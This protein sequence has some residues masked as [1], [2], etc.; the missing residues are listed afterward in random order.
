V[1]VDL[2]ALQR[3]LTPADIPVWFSDIG[4]VFGIAKAR[5][6]ASKYGFLL[7]GGGL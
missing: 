5:K 2:L 7:C 3:G 4:L 1:E 6:R